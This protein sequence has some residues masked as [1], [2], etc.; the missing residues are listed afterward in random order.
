LLGLTVFEIEIERQMRGQGRVGPKTCDDVIAPV[1]V[2][3]C[4]ERLDLRIGIRGY[5]S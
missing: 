4:R 2:S 5:V 3:F 1:L